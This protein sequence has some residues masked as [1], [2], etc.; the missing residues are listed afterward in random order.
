MS[1]TTAQIYQQFHQY[2]QTQQGRQIHQPLRQHSQRQTHQPYLRTNSNSTSPGSRAKPLNNSE[3]EL[4]GKRHRLYTTHPMAWSPMALTEKPLQEKN[5][6][7]RPPYLTTEKRKL[8]KKTSQSKHTTPT[9]TST[10]CQTP[11]KVSHL[12]GRLSAMA[13]LNS[14]TLKTSGNSRKDN[15]LGSTTWHEPAIMSQM[16]PLA[17][18]HLPT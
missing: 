6:H 3:H 1:P 12:D 13:L 14:V 8:R 4:T 9:I 17:P 18:Y 7:T 5:D 15:S 16:R 11:T 10:Y 2:Q